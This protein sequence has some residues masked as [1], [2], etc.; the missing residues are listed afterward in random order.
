MRLWLLV[1]VTWTG[2]AA[3]FVGVG[4][5]P[6]LMKPSS[7]RQACASQAPDGTTLDRGQAICRE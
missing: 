3:L 5:L 7:L 4:A 1:V 6:S 2:I